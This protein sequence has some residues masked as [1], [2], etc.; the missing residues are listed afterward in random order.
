MEGN[1]SFQ[2]AALEGKVF[3]NQMEPAESL[4]HWVNR[5]RG[6]NLDKFKYDPDVMKVDP[7]DAQYLVYITWGMPMGTYLTLPQ[8]EPLSVG[9]FCQVYHKRNLK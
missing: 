2:Q 5:Q 4:P 9:E 7:R 1:A 8:W 6:L 3:C